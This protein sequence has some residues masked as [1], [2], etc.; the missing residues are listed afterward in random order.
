MALGD[1]AHV[2]QYT[3][4]TRSYTQHDRENYESEAAMLDGVKGEKY[5]GQLNPEL[6]SY[7][8]AMQPD[9]IVAN[10]WTLPED[11][12]AVYEGRNPDTQRP[13]IKAVGKPLVGWGWWG[14]I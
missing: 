8:P 1:K 10:R 4:V 12:Y 2:G 13:L 7:K 11:L 5:I 6:R 9:H 14:G 3:L